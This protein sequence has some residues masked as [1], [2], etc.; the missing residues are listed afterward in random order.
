MSWQLINVLMHSKHVFRHK[1]VRNLKVVNI[2]VW[3]TD[4]YRKN[5][6]RIIQIILIAEVILCFNR[7]LF[8]ILKEILKPCVVFILRNHLCSP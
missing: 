8:C 5:T 4:L 6:H 2:I 3:K 7:L 1:N